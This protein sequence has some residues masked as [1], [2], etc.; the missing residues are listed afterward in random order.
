M[1]LSLENISKNLLFIGLL[2]LIY[3]SGSFS[4]SYPNPFELIF[5]VVCAVTIITALKNKRIKEFFLSIPKNIRIAACL[6]LGS[7]L[8]GW[9]VAVFVMNIPS[10]FNNVLEFGGFAIG[11]A[12]FLLIILFTRDDEV[13]A[14]KYFYALL[15]PVVY[16]PFVFFPA[17]AVRLHFAVEGSAFLGFTSNPNIISKILLIPLMFFITYAV[18]ERKNTYVKIGY[19]IVATLLVSLVF[20]TGSRAALVSMV[21]G[22]MLIGVVFVRQYFRWQNICLGFG[23]IVLI[24]S[25][26][27][28]L[29]P[30]H[31]KVG[32]VDRNLTASK[33]TL[34]ENT[35]LGKKKPLQVSVE[36]G[37]VA[38]VAIVPET[39]LRMWPVYLKLVVLHPLGFGPNTHMDVVY[40]N[41][42][43]KE[44]GPHNT[45]L[46]IWLW[47]G[48]V[49]LLS[50][51]YILFSAFKNLTTKL[52]TDG[53]PI[54]VALLA[55]LFSLSIAILFN[56]SLQLFCFWA[57]L[58]LSSKR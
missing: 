3:R 30:H 43:H 33:I 47:G 25:S 24:I 41:G 28:M 36:E 20:W 5:V 22:A 10:P 14:K 26:G 1:K 7:V 15:F 19:S 23:L 57:I 49:G 55:T 35:L 50:F 18:F 29:A 8:L 31:A 38:P 56:D 34:A 48:I 32:F 58:A 37:G 51:L 11:L 40:P 44:I 21:V 45:Y 42:E 39:R 4:N 9:F 16:I 54:T 12:L 52:H 53:N 27:Y 2:T 46:E 13:V 6:L 17:L